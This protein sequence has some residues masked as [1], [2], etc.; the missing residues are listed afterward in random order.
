MNEPGRFLDQMRQTAPLIHNITNFVAMNSMANV[1]LAAGASPAMVHCRD[2]VAEFA[3]ISSALTV[4]I[5]TLEPD[6]LDAMLIAAKVMNEHRRPWVM[7]P[8]GVGATAYRQEA[9]KELLALKPTVIRGNASEI[10][11]LAGLPSKASGVDAGNTVNDAREAAISIAKAYQSVVVVTGEID[12]ITDGKREQQVPFGS[13]LMGKVTTMGCSLN[14]IVAA[15]CVG[16]PVYE[17]TVAALTY[18]GL[19]G[20]LAAKHCK[21]PGSFWVEFVDAL[22][23]LDG[24][25]VSQDAQVIA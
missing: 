4:N 15:F 24:D 18:Y 21:G 3:G 1:L 8:V 10:M 5:G 11:T 13:P 9:A 17:A 14:G 23:S 16:Q 6:W 25:L 22:A 12:L 19:A 2:E 20:Q 7:D